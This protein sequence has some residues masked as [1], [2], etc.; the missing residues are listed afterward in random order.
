[1]ASPSP[2]AKTLYLLTDPGFGRLLALNMAVFAGLLVMVVSVPFLYE[3]TTDIYFEINGWMMST[4]H[5]MAWWWIMGLLSSSC[6][7][8][9]LI[10]NSLALGCS[11]LNTVL[12]PLR[13]TLVALSLTL[14][15]ISWYVAWSRPYQWIP[16]AVATCLSNGFMIMPELLAWRVRQKTAPMHHPTSDGLVLRFRLDNMGCVACLST[17]SGVLET[18]PEIVQ[19][20]QL[21]L[22][23]SLATVLLV[24][25]GRDHDKDVLARKN[26]VMSKLDEAGFP[27]KEAA[28]ASSHDS[29]KDKVQGKKDS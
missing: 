16:T 2:P 9:Q 10:L 6:C 28:L 22:E 11:G 19:D 12:G 8:L 21:S 15:G 29:F 1:M 4:A 27:V 24:E 23:D 14:Q 13:P 7:A 5:R 17:V 20:Y 3:K 25:A 18:I 26:L